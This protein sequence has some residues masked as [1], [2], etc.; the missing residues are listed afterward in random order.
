[1]WSQSH[2]LHQAL[3]NMQT[4]IKVVLQLLSEL[5]QLA[6]PRIV[7]M[8]S[9]KLFPGDLNWTKIYSENNFLTGMITI[10]IAP[11]HRMD[12][13]WE[14]C[15]KERA[16]NSSPDFTV[17]AS[18]SSAERKTANNVS[19][20]VLCKQTWNCQDELDSSH[21]SGIQNHVLMTVLLQGRT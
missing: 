4:R 9:T 13:T 21:S 19:L 20:F 14:V 5:R 1:M 16:L 15:S 8:H 12:L 10:L 17:K 6:G 18:A 11:D 2:T 7:A 3:A